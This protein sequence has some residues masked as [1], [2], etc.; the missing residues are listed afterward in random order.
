MA[1]MALG[2]REVDESTLSE[3]L[4]VLLKYEEDVTR[5]RADKLPQLVAEAAR[6]G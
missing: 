5:V 4:G 3:T 2:T 6:A 1:L